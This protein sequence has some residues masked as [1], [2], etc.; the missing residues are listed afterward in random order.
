MP[1]QPYL[2]VEDS[3]KVQKLSIPLTIPSSEKIMR[4]LSGE[5]LP[6]SKTLE[7]FDALRITK[8][9]DFPATPP[10]ITI[11]GA[12]VAAPANI[13]PVTAESKGGKTA[14]GS[15][16]VAGAISKDGLIDGFSDIEVVPNIE[17]RAVIHIDTEQS[18][19]DQQY[20]L[21]TA[22]RRA[23]FETTPDYYLSYNI[24]TLP[25]AEYQTFTSEV[26]RLANDKFH[27]IHLVVIDGVADYI[28]S[29]ND[30]AEANNII[31]Y[32]R[33]LAQDY[34]CPIVLV[35]HLNENAGK[36]ND[37]MPRGHLGRQAVRKGYCQLNITKNGD[38]STLQVLR[39]RKAGTANTP[40]VSFSYNVERGYHTSV[41]ANEVRYEKESK[42]AI[43]EMLKYEQV[44]REV[45][46]GQKSF[47]HKDT[48]TAIMKVASRK[49][50]AAK[51]Y[52]K[53][54]LGWDIV[55]QGIDGNYRLSERLRSR[56]D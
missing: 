42:K 17:G 56:S 3:K 19:S 13:T 43:G 18:E 30:E 6:A 39:A 10:T 54:M 34:H 52:L 47:S 41:D 55:E 24:G 33:Q 4:Q 21:V 1:G 40:L 15:V 35:V 32:F 48:I 38:I 9:K 22:L 5:D 8:E 31:L 44:A 16:L 27:G 36:N 49:S 45:F 50:T 28:Q 37:T 7:D 25:L 2:R 46:T 26:F 53:T 29:V 20:N 11:G 14:L 12:R 51:E 23:G